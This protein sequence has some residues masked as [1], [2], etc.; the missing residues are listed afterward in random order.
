MSRVMIISADC[1]AGALPTTYEAYLP[2]AYHEAARAWWLSFAREMMAHQK[3]KL[4]ELKM[5]WQ[6]P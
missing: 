3:L 4:L 2:K 5:H 6:K 1:H